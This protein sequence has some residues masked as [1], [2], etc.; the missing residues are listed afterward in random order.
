M[1]KNDIAVNLAD[2]IDEEV[3]LNPDQLW[4]LRAGIDTG[5]RLALR[6]PKYAVAAHSQVEMEYQHTADSI[7]D[8]YV[9][10]YPITMYVSQ[11]E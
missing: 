8:R 3:G 7:V 2:F 4:G 9:E 6:H 5:I 1:T 10:N 11:G